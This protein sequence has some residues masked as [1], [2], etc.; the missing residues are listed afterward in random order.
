MVD[1]PHDELRLEGQVQV[2]AVHGGMAAYMTIAT[3][4]LLGFWSGK[5]LDELL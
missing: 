3:R 2:R 5:V 1:R 4:Y